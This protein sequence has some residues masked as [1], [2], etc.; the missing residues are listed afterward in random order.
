M[1]G[2]MMN[3]IRDASA[4]KP[5]IRGRDDTRSILRDPVRPTEAQHLSAAVVVPLY[6]TALDETEAIALA[7][8]CNVL[9]RHP[10]AFVAPEALDVAPALA[11]AARTGA[12]ARVER[13]D[14]RWFKSTGTYN[15]LL[16]AK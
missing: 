10:L 11:I 3:G 15:A 7:Q 6:R 14:S 16:L 5:A 8:C 4:A 12:A 13:F 1:R 9:G 2:R